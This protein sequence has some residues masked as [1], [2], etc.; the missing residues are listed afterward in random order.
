VSGEIS[1][2]LADTYV[3]STVAPNIGRLMILPPLGTSEANPFLVT[4]DTFQY[5]GRGNSN[6]T[7]YSAW[8]DEAYYKLTQKITLTG[9]WTPIPPFDGMLDGNGFVIDG[10]TITSP[11]ITT[12]R[13]GLFASLITNGVVKNVGLVNVNIDVNANNVG[14]IAGQMGNNTRIENCYVSGTIKGNE[15]VGGIAGQISGTNAI[16]QNCYVVGSI[17]STGE[18]S[19]G[20][21]AIGMVGGIV[22]SMNSNLPTPIIQNC[23]SLASRITVINHLRIGRIAGL[24]GAFRSNYSINS[25]VT[26][27]GVQKTITSSLTGIDGFNMSIDEA[28][29]VSFWT[30]AS[31]WN[32]ASLW[33]PDIWIFTEGRLPS[34]K[35]TPDLPELPAYLQ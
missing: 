29:S 21:N 22:G 12:D 35:N 3:L 16:I 17:E 11:S 2:L 32:A 34:L 20:N 14:G 4:Q 7:E 25:I 28:K 10:L 1:S 31:N 24:G 23:V 13:Q 26:N 18:T 15:S 27:G 19:A 30:N 9:E 6:P 8:I 5:V 33:N